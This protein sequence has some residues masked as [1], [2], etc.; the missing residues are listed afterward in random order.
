MT[1]FIVDNN[2]K[3]E[4]QLM[5]A[6]TERRDLGDRSL[7]DF[8]I[9]LGRQARQ[10]LI[11]DAWRCENAK[12]LLADENVNLMEVLEQVSELQCQCNGQ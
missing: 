12:Q 4:L 7:Y 1:F 9:A 5:E 10:E 3:N 8:L 2:I 6:T 11:E